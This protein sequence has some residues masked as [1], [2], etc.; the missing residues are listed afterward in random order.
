MAPMTNDT[1]VRTDVAS[2]PAPVVLSV[3]NLDVTYPR[4]GG[5]VAAVRGVTFQLH[6]GEALGIVGETGSGK[7][8]TM[9]ALLRLLPQ[10]ALVRADAM[11]LGDRDLTA[12]SDGELR[13]LRGRE[14]SLI[15]QRPM[16]SLSPV[17]R[18]GKQLERLDRRPGGAAAPRPELS[19]LLARVG[20]GPL[21]ERLR[22]YP[23]EFS[24]GQLQRILIA[25]ASL[26]P[27]P[28]ILFADEPTATL[29]V[30]VQGQI[31]ALLSELRAELGLSLVMITHDL[32]VVAQ[33]C[34]RVIVMQRGEIVE[35]ASVQELF[36]RPR[37]PYTAQ[38]LADLT[39]PPAVRG[40]SASGDPAAPRLRVAGVSCSYA[41]PGTRRRGGRQAVPA[42]QDVSLTIP[43]GETLALVGESGCGK[44]TLAK[45]LVGLLTPVAGTIM[46]DGLDVTRERVG[47]G[48]RSGLQLISQ[49]PFSSLNRRRTIAHALTQALAVRGATP[50]DEREQR[51]RELLEQVGLDASH[52]GRYA[53]EL[54]GGQLQRVAIARALAAE[55][56]TLV[57][58][59]PTASLDVSVTARIVDLLVELQGR[60]GL[61]YV[62]ITHEIDVARHVS[63][64]TAVMYLGRIAEQGP[65]E[66]VLH[67]PR[68]PYTASLLASMPVPDP[69]RRATFR[70]L[71][72]E[73]PS[74]LSPP[75]G[76]VFRTR[77]PIA[78]DERCATEVPELRRAGASS[79]AC[80]FA[81][82]VAP[83]LAAAGTPPIA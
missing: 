51:A 9:S 20:L 24:G 60:L 57:L 2:S 8:T 41:R 11:R 39:R 17:T 33:T 66:Q 65:T 35:T 78:Q 71:A 74:P 4:R 37:H 62:W 6:E 21:A 82:D 46:L 38:L 67:R 50:A 58:D 12:L 48:Q 30:T 22:A 29:D 36:A 45:A 68:H 14:L 34:D 76:C 5:D 53:S 73:V 47:R 18:L 79:S 10:R 54:S 31:L 27:Q 52:L 80:H 43:A 64:Q 19:A 32:G 15:P 75:S 81:D 13:R 40:R 49:N 72:G 61:T 3:E 25:I 1:A 23:H 28:Q 69:T 42:V 44:S 83:R 7:T 77:C 26:A 59:E 16:T 63:E 56:R 70:P 55:P